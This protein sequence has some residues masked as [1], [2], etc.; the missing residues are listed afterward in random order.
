MDI[1]I[2][3]EFELWAEQH[4]FNVGFDKELGV[5]TNVYTEGAWLAFNAGYVLAITGCAVEA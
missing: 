4:K 2:R 1:D 3:N 5:Y